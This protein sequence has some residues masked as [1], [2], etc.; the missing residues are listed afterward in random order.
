MQIRPPSSP[1]INVY[2]GRFKLMSPMIDRVPKMRMFSTSR[3]KIRL[4]HGG[5][6]NV[7]S[8]GTMG[9]RPEQWEF[10]RGRFSLD[11]PLSAG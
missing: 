1:R 4:L 8:A 7:N 6:I 3:E 9:I 5:R 10:G 2:A 11:L